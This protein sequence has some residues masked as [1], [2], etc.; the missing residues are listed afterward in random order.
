MHDFRYL[1]KPD[2]YDRYKAVINYYDSI[3]IKAY[4][5]LKHMPIESIEFVTKE[6]K[7]L[8]SRYYKVEIKEI[9]DFDTYSMIMG[10]AD[11]EIN[12]NGTEIGGRYNIKD[13]RLLIKS[14]FVP[15]TLKEY[16]CH[17]FAHALDCTYNISD[18]EI[19]KGLYNRFYDDCNIDSR[20]I[21]SIS[22]YALVDEREFFAECFSSFNAKNNINGYIRSVLDRTSDIL[23]PI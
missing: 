4:W 21:S 1:I 23:Y 13:K 11:C 15:N 6:F 3:G 18:D 16:L 10:I 19:I 9:G 2:H 14:D 8:I 20:C 22:R 7:E 12:K 5:D 17:E